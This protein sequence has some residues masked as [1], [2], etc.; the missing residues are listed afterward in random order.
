MT[1]SEKDDSYLWD[2][3]GEPDAELARLEEVLGR[4]RHRGTVPPL[5]AR[6][7]SRVVRFPRVGARA[8]A[9]AAALILIAGAGLFVMMTARSSWGVQNIA[10]T[11]VVDG[12]TIE[13]SGRIA[14][15]SLLV[16]DAISRARLSIAQIGRVDVDP[17]TRV[18]L[19]AARGREHRLSLE[20]G[21]IHAQIWAPPKFFFVNTPSATAIDLG[22]AY[23]LQVDDSGAG[24]V[25]V[26]HGWVAFERDGRESY[27]PKGA[28]CATRPGIGPGTPRYEDAPSGYGAALDVLDFAAPNDRRRAEAFSLVL[29]AARP[30]DALTLWHLLTRGTPDE[31]TLVYD[32]LSAIAPPPRGVAREAVLAGDREALHTWWDSL[33]V[34]T[35]TWW[36]F[37]KKRW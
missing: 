12:R 7:P 35:G 34:D 10:G 17:N 11:P 23:T 31:R 18:Q 27:I 24:L 8:F 1:D 9:A 6:E 26:T 36:T 30:R 13:G 15:G 37:I 2:G 5:P 21:T 32:R 25:R 4:L 22:C 20:R 28:I 16:T 3:S 33:G 14:V 19:V 29:S